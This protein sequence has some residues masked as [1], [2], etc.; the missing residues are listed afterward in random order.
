MHSTLA[1]VLSIVLHVFSGSLM[2]YLFPPGDW[3]SQLAKPAFYPPVWMF[4]TVWTLLYAMM[5]LAF[6]LVL[7]AEGKGKRKCVA[8]VLYLTQLGVNLSFSPLFFGLRET[9]LG[10][11]VVAILVPLV[12]ATI[13]SFFRI[14]RLSSALLLPY[15]FW[16]LFALALAYRIWRLNP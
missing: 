15:F 11:A 1:P 12:A 7:R 10:L 4:P 5:G 16:D 2:G 14:S 9:F 6:W 13:I 8:I 3:T